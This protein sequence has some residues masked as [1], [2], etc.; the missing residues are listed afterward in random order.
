[1]DC[2]KEIVLLCTLTQSLFTAKIL[3]LEEGSFVLLTICR[4]GEEAQSRVGG[5]DQFSYNY[6]TVCYIGYNAYTGGPILYIMYHQNSNSN[7]N[8]CH[9]LTNLVFQAF[10]RVFRLFRIS[11]CPYKVR[12]RQ[13]RISETVRIVKKYH[14]RYKTVQFVVNIMNTET[15]RSR[16]D[17]QLLVLTVV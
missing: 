15:L 2:H 6:S 3:L 5:K 13:V 17:A 9:H 1:M 8:T 11:T 7:S 4:S 14:V 10:L 12:C 16:L